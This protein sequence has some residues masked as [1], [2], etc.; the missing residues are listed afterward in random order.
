MVIPENAQ[1][2]DLEPF[3]GVANRIT[4]LY[5]FQPGIDVGPLR[6]F[7]ALTE[8][9][10]QPGRA[11]TVD[12]DLDAV[13]ALRTLSTCRPT[14]FSGGAESGLRDLHVERPSLD[15]LEILVQLPRLERLKIYG[16]FPQHAPTSL[17]CGSV[18][19]RPPQPAS[20]PGRVAPDQG[21]SPCRPESVRCVRTPPQTRRRRRAHVQVLRPV[22][23]QP[24]PTDTHR[25]RAPT[26]A[27]NLAACGK[28]VYLLVDVDSGQQYVGSA[29]GA[30]ILLGR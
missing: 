3:L 30:D 11:K 10:I 8:L 6:G 15:A 7:S 1:C 5:V 4:V 21:H 12:L 29:K 13:P 24:A 19:P 20:Q 14:R 28:G 22:P 18:G 25:R 16:A 23:Q 27:S 26:G 2:L 17:R 9:I